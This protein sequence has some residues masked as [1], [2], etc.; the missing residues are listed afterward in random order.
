MVAL[1]LGAK[2]E[3]AAGPLA[4]LLW[5]GAGIF[6]STAP[7]TF[8]T[9]TNR[10]HFIA[11]ALFLADSFGLALATL[12]IGPCGW[13]LTGAAIARVVTAWLLCGLYLWFGRK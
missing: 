4:L 5:S 12:L 10:Q 1:L 9:I 8:L 2:Y 11:L 6:A 13:G 7:V 3:H